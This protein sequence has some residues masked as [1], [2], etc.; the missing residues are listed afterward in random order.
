MCLSVCRRKWGEEQT[1][2]QSE[3]PLV[4]HEG[5]EQRFGGHTHNNVTEHRGTVLCDMVKG[6]VLCHIYSV[7]VYEREEEGH[8]PCLA[9]P[10]ETKA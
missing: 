4:T 2:L 1:H 7:T 9:Q 6:S 8:D 10:K 5:R 3:S